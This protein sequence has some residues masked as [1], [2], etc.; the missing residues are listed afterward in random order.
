MGP[1]RIKSRGFKKMVKKD[2]NNG[3]IYK[4]GCLQSRQN[5]KFIANLP[6]ENPRHASK[7]M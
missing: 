6:K 3:T 7:K 5:E 1:L 2:Q 4:L